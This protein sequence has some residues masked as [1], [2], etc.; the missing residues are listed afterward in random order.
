MTLSM[1]AKQTKKILTLLR[2]L[3]LSIAFHSLLQQT[4]ELPKNNQLS[5]FV[6]AVQGQEHLVEAI[7]KGTKIQS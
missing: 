5:K 3:E 2:L 1:K 7:I 6:S 4:E